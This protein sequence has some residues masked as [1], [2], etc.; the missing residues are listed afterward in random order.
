MLTITHTL[1]KSIHWFTVSLVCLAIETGQYRLSDRGVYGKGRVMQII[2]CWVLP[3]VA[4]VPHEL[5][6]IAETLE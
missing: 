3:V 6:V 1:N 4:A 5:T 2:S